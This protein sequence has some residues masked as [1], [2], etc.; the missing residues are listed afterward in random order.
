[1]NN[2]KTILQ[3]IFNNPEEKLLLFDNLDIINIYEKENGK[4]YLKSFDKNETEKLVYNE[5]TKKSAPEEIVRQLYLHSLIKYYRYSKDLIEIEKSVNFGREQKRADIVVFRDDGITPKIIVETKAP[6][7]E[8]DIQQLKSYLNAEGAPVGVGING[9][10]KIILYRPYPKEFD[11]TLDDIP[12]A[13]EEIENVLA[14][15]KTLR[16]LKE[17]DLRRIIKNLEELVLANSGKESFDEIFKLIYAKLY[18]ERE[19]LSRENEKLF[20][21]KSPTGKPEETKKIIDNLFEDARNEWSDVFK[22]GDKI[23]LT[24]EHLSV[25]VGELQDVKLFGSNLRIIDEAFEYLLPDVAKRKKGQYFTPRV[26]IDMCVKMLNPKNKEYVIDSACGSAGFLV[27]AMQHVWRTLL[28]KEARK[29]YASRYLFGI[30]F[31]EKST[32]ISRAIMLIAGDGKSHIYKTTSLDTNEWAGSLKDELRKLDLLT[33]FKDFEDNKL[34]QDHF[35]NLEFDLLLANPPFAGQIKQRKLLSRY[36]LAK[37]KKGKIK[38]KVSRHILFI[39]RNLN[40]VKEGGRL[41][42]VLPQGIF[43]NISQINIRDYII[44]RAK[45]LAVVGLHTNSFKPHTG[46]KTSIIFLQKW[47]KNELGQGGEP[48]VKDYPIF[49]A[50]SEKSFKN[51]SGDYVFEKDQSGDIL[52]NEYGD[53]KYQTD[54][55]DIANAFIKWGTEHNL[56]FLQNHEEASSR[57]IP[58]SMS[59]RNLKHCLSENRFDA[60]YWHP[61]HDN[62]LREIKKNDYISLGKLFDLKKG[63]EVGSMEYLSDGIPFIRVSN[64]GCDEINEDRQKYISD[65]LYQKYETR[66]QP[67]IGEI[68]FT[69]DA[70]AGIA[71]LIRENKKQIISGGIVRLIL[72]NKIKKLTGEYLL[73]CLNSKIVKMQVTRFCGGSIIQHLKPNDIS[74]IIIPILNEKIISEVTEN[75]KKAYLLRKNAKNLYIKNDEMTKINI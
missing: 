31:D 22:K 35:K 33:E 54:L 8:N 7:E 72:K 47:K 58:K 20:F 29:D 73:S 74:K 1:M 13:D 52:K 45:I 66:Y 17:K 75:V 46:T 32:K 53:P 44:K 2:T 4:Y 63:V 24:P 11:D 3:K 43:D 57:S 12:K 21:R 34:N 25:C 15:K 36:A 30:D 9:Q 68:I 49:F 50:T 65:N 56:D 6:S 5:K 23:E 18:D 42:I 51:N 55:D 69:K 26:V 16:D 37:D 40:L 61:Q 41:A 10:S 19:A 59:I 62:L 28:N 71:C 14:K 38:N 39:E 70:T 27:H 60:E 64:L 48:K 67:K